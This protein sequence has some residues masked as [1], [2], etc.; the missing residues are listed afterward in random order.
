MEID[1]AN[2]PGNDFPNVFFCEA[3]DSSAQET[4]SDVVEKS[5]NEP[6]IHKNLLLSA[7]FRDVLETEEGSSIPTRRSFLYRTPSLALLL[8][9]RRLIRLL[10]QVPITHR[11][12]RSIHCPLQAP[13]RPGSWKLLPPSDR[14]TLPLP[15]RSLFVES[16]I[17]VQLSSRQPIKQ[18]AAVLHPFLPPKPDLQAPGFP[19]AAR[20]QFLDERF[21]GFPL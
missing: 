14:Q 5:F 3:Y 2:D 6:L 10:L 15:F 8:P 7:V 21:R 1:C 9:F 18:F 11:T 16:S 17:V 20:R 12:P 13:C 19:F 4:S